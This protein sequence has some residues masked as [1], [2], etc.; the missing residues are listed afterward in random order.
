[1]RSQRIGAHCDPPNAEKSDTAVLENARAGGAN[2]QVQGLR[3][4]PSL[5]RATP[6][7]KLESMLSPLTYWLL[8]THRCSGPASSPDVSLHILHDCPS[9]VFC[10]VEFEQSHKRY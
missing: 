3:W 9:S 10:A 7:R 5:T 4:A 2:R 6:F 1:M 8:V